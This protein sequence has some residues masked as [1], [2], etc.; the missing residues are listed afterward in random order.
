MSTSKYFGFVSIGIATAFLTTVTVYRSRNQTLRPASFFSNWLFEL[1][2]KIA[3]CGR[4]L[5][6]GDWENQI[7]MR[8][9]HL[10][11]ES[12]SHALECV[13]GL[14]SQ[15]QLNCVDENAV[16]SESDKTTDRKPI[17]KIG[18][19][20]SQQKLEPLQAKVNEIE[21]MFENIIERLD[22]VRG[23]FEVKA[24]RKALIKRMNEEGLNKIDRIRERH[25]LP[26]N[27][28]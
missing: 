4:I 14:E 8:D 21:N 19:N 25:R 9:I 20:P 7:Y 15:F 6:D 13:T 1:W 11:E 17:R 3:R 27:R 12:A 28:Y 23:S 18:S 2:R 16:R 24:A 22:I 5:W 10:L 26:Q